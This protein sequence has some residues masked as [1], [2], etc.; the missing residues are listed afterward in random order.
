MSEPRI[1]QV[2]ESCWIIEVH[3]DKPPANNSNHE[4]K[5]ADCVCTPAEEE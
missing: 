2:S 5:D 4:C 1:I 3:D